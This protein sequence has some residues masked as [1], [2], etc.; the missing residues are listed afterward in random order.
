[1]LFV[2]RQLVFNHRQSLAEQLRQETDAAMALHLAAVLLIHVHTQSMIHAPG[3]C[4]PLIIAFL[5]PHLLADHYSTL[6]C[7]QGMVQ[8]GCV[9]G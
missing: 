7:C 8:C 4:V 3:R 1:M 6:L 5:K 2:D 9:R